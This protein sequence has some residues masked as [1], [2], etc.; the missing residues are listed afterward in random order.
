MCQKCDFRS[1]LLS[2]IFPFPFYFYL[3]SS[4]CQIFY[5][6]TNP[7]GFYFS[8]LMYALL[9]PNL[10]LSL[11]PFCF[12]RFYHIRFLL[13]FVLILFW[14]LFLSTFFFI[15][16]TSWVRLLPIFSI[17][18]F[19]LYITFFSFSSHFLLF[20]LSLSLCPFFKFKY[21]ILFICLFI[22]T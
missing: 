22:Y 3:F 13:H 12:F 10:S 11:L 2:H 18:L 9:L 7:C 14:P 19:C 15:S 1:N 6:L 20:A 21:H 8:S 16:F 5:E 4:Q 17:L